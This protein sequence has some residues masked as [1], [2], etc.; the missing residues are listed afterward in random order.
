MAL[1]HDIASLVEASEALTS[2]VDNKIQSIDS[3]V[4][5]KMAEVNSALDDLRTIGGGGVGTR[6]IGVANIYT[7]AGGKNNVHLKLPLKL[8]EHNEMFHITV[9]G[10]G[11]GEGKLVSATFT[12]YCFKDSD[13]LT[14][15]ECTGTHNPMIY[16]GRDN[17]V[18][19][20]LS[21][22]TTY[23]LTLSVDTMRVGNGRLI[24]H[25]DIEVIFS[26]NEDA[27]PSPA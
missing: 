22:E 20:R 24:K 6:A 26:K 14:N 1:E 13:I 8:T 5:S 9:T 18:Y 10:Y 7:Q 4:S 3:T 23:F 12:G 16:R 21:F 25:G 2:T 17:H 27:S 19:C 11:Y 15:M